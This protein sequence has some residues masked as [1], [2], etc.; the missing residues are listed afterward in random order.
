MDSASVYP[1]LISRVWNGI[2]DNRQ[3]GEEEHFGVR[4]ARKVVF[5]CS[6]CGARIPGFQL[7][8]KHREL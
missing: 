7:R 6:E 2:T 1:T 8:A 3:S 5:T 4:Y